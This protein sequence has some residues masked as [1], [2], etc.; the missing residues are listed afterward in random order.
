MLVPRE[1]KSVEAGLKAKGF[2]L[3]ESHHHYFIYWTLE[4][5]KTRARTH[6]SHTP[7]MKDIPDNLLPQ[8]ARQ[9]FLNKAQFLELIDCPLSRACRA[10]ALGLDVLDWEY[11][12]AWTTLGIGS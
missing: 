8:M 7:K 4:G 9:C 2:Q 5:K 6:T 11:V 12:R 10:I 1:K 3:Q